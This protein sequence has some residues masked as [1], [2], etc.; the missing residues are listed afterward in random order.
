MIDSA[1]ARGLFGG[2][3]F[4]L[5][6][7]ESDFMRGRFEKTCRGTLPDDFMFRLSENEVASLRSQ[8]VILKKRRG[9]DTKYLLYAFT[10][11]CET[12]YRLYLR[13]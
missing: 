5:T 8:S 6:P 4:T 3:I 9:Q 11:H 7:A 12:G 10:E 1:P 2:R 13:H